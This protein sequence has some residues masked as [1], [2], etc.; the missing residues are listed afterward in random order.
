[1]TSANLQKEQFALVSIQTITILEKGMPLVKTLE[2]G[3]IESISFLRF[4]G[5][6]KRQ[7]QCKFIF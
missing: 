5:Y 3:H 2:T 4:E 6:Q 1:M 7:E